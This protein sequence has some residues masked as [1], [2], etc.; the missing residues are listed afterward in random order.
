MAGVGALG[1]LVVL[2][3][4]LVAHADTLV[5]GRLKGV[6]ALLNPVA[7]EAADPNNHRFT[8]REPSATVSQQAKILTAFLPKELCVV[9]LGPESKG[10][11]T[12]RVVVSGGRTTPVTIVVNEGQTLQFENHD[13]FVHRLYDVGGKG[14]FAVAETAP[15]AA[16]SWT[17]PP[18]AATYE[19][20]DERAPSLRTWV[21]V[22]PKA[23]RAVTPNAAHACGVVTR[24]GEFTLS[25]PEGKFDL[26]GYFKGAP[27]GEA[28]PVEVKAGKDKQDLPDPLVVGKAES[29]TKKGG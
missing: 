17:P 8:F 3:A 2:A 23:T 26:R 16:R 1:A 4:P 29:D 5:K 21:V 28:L 15:K 22:E 14:G 6:E 7:T 24:R 25:L 9:A 11:G 27:V 10:Q 19:L 18:G 20:R 13:P 12:A